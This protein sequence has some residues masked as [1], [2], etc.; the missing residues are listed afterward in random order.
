MTNGKLIRELIA[1][2]MQIYASKLLQNCHEKITKLQIIL[3]FYVRIDDDYRARA[4][5][6]AAVGSIVRVSTKIISIRSISTSASIPFLSV[7]TNEKKRKK[8][9]RKL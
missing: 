6:H 4:A 3:S 5:K 1:F 8:Q 9:K 7:T 2:C